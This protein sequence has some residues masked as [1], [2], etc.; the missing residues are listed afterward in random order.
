MF[1]D[2]VSATKAR[3]LYGFKKMNE[4]TMR[5]EQSIMETQKNS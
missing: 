2:G 1:K 4:R 3:Q 5:V